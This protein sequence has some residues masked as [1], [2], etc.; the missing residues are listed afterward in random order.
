MP[1]PFKPLTPL[2]VL[3]PL[4]PLDALDRRKLERDR[5]YAE[6]EALR[7]E[8]LQDFWRGTDAVLATAAGAAVRA[9]QRLASRLRRHHVRRA[10]CVGAR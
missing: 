8:A 10:D 9:A 7:R 2:T 6:A 5:A 3:T 1:Q 4:Q